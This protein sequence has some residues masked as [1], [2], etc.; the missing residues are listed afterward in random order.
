MICEFV[1]RLL[2]HMRD[3]RTDICVP[4]LRPSD[5]DMPRRPWIDDFS[6]NYMQ[7]AMPKM[8]KQGDREPWLNTQSYSADRKLIAKAPIDDGVMRFERARDQVAA[9]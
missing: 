7:R 5:L 3:T 2:N 8:P 9:G 4:R 1:C 6:A